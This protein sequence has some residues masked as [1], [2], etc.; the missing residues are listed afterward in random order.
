MNESRPYRVQPFYNTTAGWAAD[1]AS[2]NPTILEFGELGVEDTGSVPRVK[3]GNGVSSW[4][5]L[6]YLTGGAAPPEALQDVLNLGNSATTLSSNVGTFTLDDGTVVC[7]FTPENINWS[8][9]GFGFLMA[10]IGINAG[11][12]YLQLKDPAHNFYSI[13]QAGTLSATRNYSGPDAS[14]TIVLDT[15]AQKL[16]TKRNQSRYNT[17][18]TSSTPTINSDTTDIFELTAQAANI[19]SFSTNLTGSPD[20][21]DVIHIAITS[22]GTITIAWGAKFESSSAFLPSGITGAGRVDCIF[23]WKRVTSSTGIWR[24][25]NSF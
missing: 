25:V 11:V 19:T 16:T 1:V 20:F 4:T 18:V 24:L 14:G 7:L 13:F 8:P 21:D 17:Q 10:S 15:A 2:P 22:T 23:F 12:A 5:G 9:S 6:A 3:L